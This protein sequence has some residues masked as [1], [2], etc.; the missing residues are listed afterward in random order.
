M[1][2]TNLKIYTTILSCLVIGASFISC[3]KVDSAPDS[4]GLSQGSLESNSSN[5]TDKITEDT[6]REQIEY[7]MELTKSLQDELLS[8]RQ[9]YYIGESEYKATIYQLRSDIEKLEAQLNSSANTDTNNNSSSDP[10]GSTGS[11]NVGFDNL[12]AKNL[13]NYVESNGEITISGYTGTST[14]VTIPSHIDS[15]PVT[16][17]GEEAFKGKNVTR[18]TLPST[19]TKIDWFAFAGCTSLNEISISENVTSVGYGAFDYCPNDMKI[20]CP[21]GSYIETYAHSW[22]ITTVTP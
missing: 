9:E 22:G 18:V 12:A 4:N 17:I 19:V 6:Y 16:A 15:Y 2:K 3:A 1:K 8:A 20:I 21:N 14:D 7:Y 5:V 11:D 13:F 10:L